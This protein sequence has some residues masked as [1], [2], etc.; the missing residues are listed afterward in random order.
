M[1]SQLDPYSTERAELLR[2]IQEGH[3]RIAR[4]I[5]RSS[6]EQLRRPVLDDWT[7]KDLLAH[8]ASW[9]DHSVRVIDSLIAGRQPYDA[10]DPANTTDAYNAR[11][12]RDHLDDP[13]G[14]ARQAFAD[15]FARLL[16]AIESLS[17]EDLFVDERWPWLGGEALAEMIQWD[18]SRHYEAHHEHLQRGLAAA[19][20]T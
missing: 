14:I 4:L 17:G 16:T 9:H 20:R 15:S 12:H 8:M 2:S 7:G 10:D 13:P 19:T 18:S 11:T 1:R 5:D 6:D 3:Q